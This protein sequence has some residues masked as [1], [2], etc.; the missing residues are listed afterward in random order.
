M[1]VAIKRKQIVEAAFGLLDEGGIE[2]VNLRKLACS[3]GIRA[4]SLYWHFT[5]KQALID[6]V[7]DTDALIQDIAREIPEEQ[8]RRATLQ[9]IARELRQGF[10]S[11]RDGARVHAGTYIAS[12]NVL[13]VAEATIAALV[14]AG[15]EIEL[16]ASTAL[17]LI[18]YVMGFVIEEQALPD[19]GGDIAGVQQ[20]LHDLAEARDPHC[21]QARQALS[22][23]NFK[24]RFGNGVDLL[25][26]GVQQR[27]I[28]A[29]ARGRPMK[30]KFPSFNLASERP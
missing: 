29:R 8:S 17:D 14:G 3:L 9:Q 19:R 4:P 1:R 20:A 24:A 26:D 23:P 25:L 10:K 5:S 18:C 15:A 7:T 2:G 11:H 22:E 16:A 6:A 27:L 28:N 13:R 30:N 21:W 12:E